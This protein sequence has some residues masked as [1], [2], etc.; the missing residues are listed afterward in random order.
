M[1]VLIEGR[2][3]GPSDS[4]NGGYAAGAAAAAL[5][6]PLGPV[7]VT[8][9]YPPPLDRPLQVSRTAEGVSVGFDDTTV[10]SARTAELNVE[11]PQVVSYEQAT[12]AAKGFPWRFEHPYPR[13]FVCGTER[14][15][16]LRIHPGPVDGHRLAA[17][18]WTPDGSLADSAGVVRP[19]VVWAS[20]DCPSWF[21]YGCFEPWQGLFLLGRFT[22]RIDRLPLVDE[23][24]VLTGWDLG[25]DGRKHDSAAAL[26]SAEGE[27]L[28]LS[29]ALWITL[30]K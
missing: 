2:Y 20:V 10:A 4:G 23:P 22:A 28:A 21:G 12:D 6:S 17:A 24:C 16:G 18:P 29:R 30:K 26:H 25:R 1:T 14:P 13:C 8:L 27:L 7:E 19:E 15:D 9:R 11:P 5:G 3:C